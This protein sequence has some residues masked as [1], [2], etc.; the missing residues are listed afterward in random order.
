MKMETKETLEKNQ[1]RTTEADTKTKDPESVYIRSVSCEF[2]DSESPLSGDPGGLMCL[3]ENHDEACGWR[4]AACNGKKG[5]RGSRCRPNTTITG[6]SNP[7]FPSSFPCLFFFFFFCFVPFYRTP[8][9]G[10]GPKLLWLLCADGFR[11]EMC[12]ITTARASTCTSRQTANVLPIRRLERAHPGVLF[13]LLRRNCIA[14]ARWVPRD[15]LTNSVRR[16]RAAVHRSAKSVRGRRASVGAAAHR[17]AVGVAR[18]VARPT[19]VSA[20]GASGSNLKFF[21]ARRGQRVC[22]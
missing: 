5:R 12:G 11:I 22:S 15:G 6:G 3:D 8:M 9:G 2:V 13:H 20:H 4:L 14:M 17:W 21:H 18:R 10:R 1:E 7:S 16:R 19:W